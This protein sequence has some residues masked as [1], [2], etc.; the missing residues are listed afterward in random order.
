MQIALPPRQ[1][2]GWLWLQMKDIYYIYNFVERFNMNF[3]VL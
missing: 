2:E 1:L 3:H